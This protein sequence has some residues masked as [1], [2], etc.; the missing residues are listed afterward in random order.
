MK[1]ECKFE[2]TLNLNQSGMTL[3]K[4]QEANNQIIK[5]QVIKYKLNIG[6]CCV[7]VVQQLLSQLNVVDVVTNIPILD[8]AIFF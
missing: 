7:G 3:E 1:L 4:L 5:K 8:V 2:S 6:R